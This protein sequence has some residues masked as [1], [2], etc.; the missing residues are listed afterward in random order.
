[1]EQ[2]IKSFWNAHPCGEFVVD[3]QF[4]AE[5]ERFFHDYDAYRYRVERHIPECLDAIDWKDK[6]VL[7]IGLGQGADSEQL[8]RRGARWSGLDLTPEAVH[9]VRTRL[10]LRQLPYGDIR[11]GS[12]LE[13][14]YA[15]GTFDK[16]Y[17]HGVL[18]HVPDIQRAS[19]QIAKLLRPGGELVMMMYARWSLNYYLTM[20]L[21][22]RVA[23]A[24]A[25]LAGLHSSYALRGGYV[26]VIKQYGL[27]NYLRMTNFVHHNTDGPLCPYSGVYD[28]ARVR[29]DFPDF[30][31][32]RSYKR[33]MTCGP[34]PIRNLTKGKWLGW[35]L[36]VHLTPR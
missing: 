21:F 12:I 4:T 2:Q 34:L 13:P 27:L 36:W 11:V 30:R 5:A 28:L 19:A 16:I 15:P 24:G 18:H 7:E 20:H 3:A 31:I 23:Q 6:E 1:M 29:R 26:D 8:I 14:P 17:S 32:V 22:R 25:Y 9:R 35:H 10:T 33:F